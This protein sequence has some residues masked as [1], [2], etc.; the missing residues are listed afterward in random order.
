MNNFIKVFPKAMSDVL[1]DEIIANWDSLRND[2]FREDDNADNM[3]FYNRTDSFIPLDMRHG[4][5][6]DEHGK[7]KDSFRHKILPLIDEYTSKYTDGLGMKLPIPFEFEGCQIQK[8]SHKDSG[9]YY[10]FHYEQA[11]GISENVTRRVLVW[12]VYLNDVPVGEGETEFL[13]QGL[14]VQ[15]KKGDLVVWPAAFTHTHRGNPVYTTDKY[16]AT[17]WILWPRPEF[18]QALH[19]GEHPNIKEE[20]LTSREEVDKNCASMFAHL[21][22]EDLETR[23]KTDK[24]N[25]A[26]YA[27]QN[28]TMSY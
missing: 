26:M 7:L 19:N 16:I 1:S 22:Q 5:D 9:G 28:K 17:G 11:G 8:Y 6:T 10:K 2:S 3:D 23:E 12:M 24:D 27:V 13:Y 18:V 15:P 21:K 20:D 14:R 25:A 4:N